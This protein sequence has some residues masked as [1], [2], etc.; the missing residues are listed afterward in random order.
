LVGWLVYKEATKSNAFYKT[1]TTLSY[2]QKMK[3][4]TLLSIKMILIFKEQ[5]L[6][7]H[8]FAKLLL[9]KYKPSLSYKPKIIIIFPLRRMP[10]T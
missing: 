7:H 6:K 5:N 9:K 3:M 4:V 10:N 2:K 1:T 8:H